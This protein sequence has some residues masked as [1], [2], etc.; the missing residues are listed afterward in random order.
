M[1]AIEKQ[2]IQAYDTQDLI[3]LFERCFAKTHQT[4]L[5]KG[6]DEPIYLPANANQPFHH[7]VFAHGFFASALHEI[8][9]WLVAGSERRLLE[10]YGYWYAPDGRNAA[11]Q[12]EF[13]QVEVAPQAM[14]WILSKACGR[15]FRLSLDNLNGEPTDSYHF[16]KSVHAQIAKY[17]ERGLNDRASQFRDS[18]CKFYGTSRLLTL[19]DFHFEEIYRG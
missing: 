13:E 19:G 8:A 1:Q 2:D 3:L 15:S 18:L 5:I 10:D 11:Q 12:A 17:I 9:H 16:A 7:V 4:K 14:E 6:V